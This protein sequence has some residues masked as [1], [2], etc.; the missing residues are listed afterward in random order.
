MSDQTNTSSSGS[1]SAFLLG[2]AFA[3]LAVIGYLLYAN[4][5]DVVDQPDVRID[6]PGVGSIEG[7][8]DGSF[9][10]T[11]HRAWMDFKSDVLPREEKIIIAE[12]IRGEEA[13]LE[14]YE[15]VLQE[16]SLPASLRTVIIDQRNEVQRSLSQLKEWQTLFEQKTAANKS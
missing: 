9:K 2:G 1:I 16:S 5:G 11:L 15:K 7:D 10:A 14:T 6:V 12:C 3:A 13:A 4:G 8:V